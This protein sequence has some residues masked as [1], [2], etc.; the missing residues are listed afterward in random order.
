MGTKQISP[1]R[2]KARAVPRASVGSAAAGTRR[3]PARK[4]EKA[5]SITNNRAI[6]PEERTALIA[7]AAYLRAEKREFT[8]GSEW[9]DWLEAE[10]EVDAALRRK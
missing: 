10:A 3:P 4:G 1:S 5:P 8:A 2:G 9:D 6:T 7:E